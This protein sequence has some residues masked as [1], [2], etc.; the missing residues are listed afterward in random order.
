VRDKERPSIPPLLVAG[1]AGV[2]LGL[3]GTYVVVPPLGSSRLST[4]Q[5]PGFTVDLPSGDI[6]SE[7]HSYPTGKLAL[8]INGATTVALIQWEPGGELSDDELKT[9]ATGI[10]AAAG[11]TSPGAITAVDGVP[12][13]EVSTAKGLFEVSM[14]KCGVRHVAIAT[15]GGDDGVAKLHRRIVA[16]FQC[17]PD[18]AKEAGATSLVF[19]L[20]LDVPGWHA[21]ASDPEQT[22]ITDGSSSLLLQ[23][24]VPDLDHDVV[25]F[26]ATLAKSKG[27]DMTLG[28]V[29][30]GRAP[31]TLKNGS[32][33]VTGFVQLVSCPTATAVVIAIVPD[34]KHT[35]AIEAIIDHGRCLKP[36]ETAQK[37]PTADSR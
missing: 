20:V 28:A 14:Q 24:A 31:M 26:I 10:G 7:D 32:D 8:A 33:A 5:F 25:S 4:H 15:G 37:F 2:G 1:V 22:Q 18:A 29:T 21:I 34:D 6:R 3:A 19:P 9:I 36:G 30:N 12:T 27:F 17:H 13:I 11:G 35:P 23:Q 16:S